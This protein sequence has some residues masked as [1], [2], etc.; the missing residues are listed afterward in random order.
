[1]STPNVTVYQ[2]KPTDNCQLR[3]TRMKLFIKDQ[4]EITST[5]GKQAG[6]LQEGKKN[7]SGRSP[8]LHQTLEN[9]EVMSPKNQGKKD[10][11][12]ES[13]RQPSYRL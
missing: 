8:Q 2:K 4:Q 10:V 11:I 1:M 7:L 6:H 13:D 3:Y 12:Q 5:Q 9:N